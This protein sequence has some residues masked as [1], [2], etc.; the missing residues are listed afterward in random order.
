MLEKGMELTP[1]KVSDKIQSVNPKKITSIES[2]SSSAP[3]SGSTPKSSV[4]GN[5]IKMSQGALDSAVSKAQLEPDRITAQSKAQLERAQADYD[6]VKPSIFETIVNL[7]RTVVDYLSG[8]PKYETEE[9]SAARK[10]LEAAKAG[11]YDAKYGN[12]E[13]KNNVLAYLQSKET[14]SD[15]ENA[16]ER[17]LREALYGKASVAE[18]IRNIWNAGSTSFEKNFADT[19]DTIAGFFGINIGWDDKAG[20]KADYWSEKTAKS[21]AALG[22]DSNISGTLGAAAVAAVPDAVAA[23]I[24]ALLTC[25]A[26]APQSAVKI[27]DTS[28]KIIGAIGK[29]ITAAAKNPFYYTSFAREFGSNYKEAKASGVSDTAAAAIATLTS[30]LNAF[31]EVGGGTGAAGI[32]SLPDRIKD[33]KNPASAV[34]EWV[35]S[36]LDEGKEEAVQRAIS[37]VIAKLTYDS[38]RELN[39]QD[40][41][42]DFASG[43]AVGGLLGGGQLAVSSALNSSAKARLTSVG[44]ML[45]KQGNEAVNDIVKYSLESLN[46][47][48]RAL[49]AASRKNISNENLGRLYANAVN[50]VSAQL[51]SVDSLKQLNTV[52]REI[53]SAGNATVNQIAQAEYIKNLPTVTEKE[54]NSGNEQRLGLVGEA[55]K[56][57]PDGITEIFTEFENDIRNGVVYS[58]DLILQAAKLDA[59]INSGEEISNDE[60]GRFVFDVAL[61]KV[62]S[63]K[64][65]DSKKSAEYNGE[66]GGDL[67]NDNVDTGRVRESFSKSAANNSGGTGEVRQIR[68]EDV[69]TFTRRHSENEGTG[70]GLIKLKAMAVA[71][72]EGIDDN[73]AGYRASQLLSDLGVNAVYCDGNIEINKNGVTQIIG[74]A[75]TLQNGQVLVSGNTTLTAAEIAAHEIV[76]VKQKQ[77]SEEYNAFESCVAENILWNTEN[78]RN[79]A[80]VINASHFNGKMDVESV[81]FADDFLIEVTAYINELV[82]TDINRAERNFAAMCADWQAVVNASRQFNKDI[83]ADFTESAFINGTKTETDDGRSTLFTEA[84]TK[85]IARPLTTEDHIAAMSGRQNSARIRQLNAVAK[86]LGVTLRWNGNISRGRYNP[87]AR[88]VTLNPETTL[89]DAYLFLFKHELTHDLENRKKY[90]LFSEYLYNDSVAFGEYC[91]QK[92]FDYYKEEYAGTREDAINEWT[93]IIYDNY[94][95]SSEIGKPIR[96]KF[97]FTDAKRE[98]IAD[99]VGECLLNGSEATTIK[100]LTEIAA[101]KPTVFQRIRDWVQEEISKLKG[102]KY[103]RTLVEDL[104]YLNKRLARVYNSAIKVDNNRAQDV[105]YSL[106]NKQFPPYSKSQ[107]D[108]NEWATRWALSEN[109]EVGDQKLAS[110]N[111]GW[112]LIEKFDDIE[113]GYQIVE[114]ITKRMYSELKEEIADVRDFEESS[115]AT[116]VNREGSRFRRNNGSSRSNGTFN[117]LSNEYTGKDTEILPLDGGKLG[118]DKVGKNIS[119]FSGKGAERNSAREGN[120]SAEGVT[121]A[122]LNESAFSLPAPVKGEYNSEQYAR[123]LLG[124]SASESQVEG[125]SENLLEIKEKLTAGDYY[126]AVQKAGKVAL[127]VWEVAEEY[128]DVPSLTNQILRDI[129][130]NHTVR[131]E[132]DSTTEKMREAF[133]AEVTRLNKRISKLEASNARKTEQLARRRSEVQRE[134][135]AR[136]DE[137]NNR[138]K[139]IE[140]I[141]REVGNI[142]KKLR[143]NNEKNPVPQELQETVKAFCNVFLRNDQT[144]FKKKDL[145]LVYLAYS[146]MAGEYQSGGESL[147]GTYDFDIDQELKDLISMLDGKTLRQLSL[148]ELQYIRDI[149]DNLR[150]M[151]VNENKL[152]V[153]GRTADIAEIGESALIEMRSRPVKKV[154]ALGKKGA[155]TIFEGNTTPIYFFKKLG[156]T[157]KILFDD[158]RDGQDKWYVNMENAKT[159]ISAT[160]KK[161][162]YSDWNDDTFKFTTV[163]GD[164]IELTREQAMLLYATAKRE[165]NNTAQ[166]AEHLFRGGIVLDFKDDIKTVVRDFKKALKSDA[167]EAESGGDSQKQTRAKEIASAFIKEVNSRAHQITPVDVG[168]VNEWLTDEQ[169]AYADEMVEYLSTDMAALGNETSMQL[170]GIRKYNEKYYIPYN[171]ARNFLYSQ[172]GI[173]G[174]E[175][176]LKHQSFTKQTQRKANNPLLL[177]DFSEVCADHINRMCMYNALTVPLENLNR[178]FNYSNSSDV[179]VSAKDMKAEIERAYGEGAVKYIKKFLEDMNG[180]VRT[181]SIDDVMSRYISLFKKGAVF[182]S[183]SVVVQQPSAIAR[184]FAIVD[185]KYFVATTLKVSERNYE[186]CIKYAP[187]AGIKSMGRF[188]TG[189]GVE[190]VNW[191]LQEEPKGVK[192]KVKALASI[193]DSSYRDDKLSYFAAKADEITWGHIWA[194]IKAE[195]KAETDLTPGTEE[196]FEYAG[197]R[198]RNVIDYTQVYD[199]TLSRSQNM[200]DKSAASKMITAFMAEPTV[201]LNLIMDGVLR[202]KSGDKKAFGRAVAAWVS[203]VLLNSFLKSFVT[204]ARDDNEKKSYLEKYLGN[205]VGNAASDLFIPNMIPIVK[206]VVSIFEGWEVER[207]D[208]SLFSDLA[209]SVEAVWN[210]NKTV[211][212]KIKSIAGSL[213]AFAGLPVKNVIRDIEAVLNVYNDIF[214]GSNETTGAGIGYSILEDLPGGYDGGVTELYKALS[215]AAESGNDKRYQRIYDYLI[216]QGKSD[217]DI[218]SG[219]KSAYKKD[220]ETESAVQKYY[221]KLDGNETFEMLTAEDREKVEKEI[222]NFIAADKY[223]KNTD[224]NYDEYDELYEAYRTDKSKYNRLKKKLLENGATES[225]ISDGFEIARIAYLKKVG[226]DLHEYILAK[227]AMKK[228]YADS[229]DSGGVSK[230]EKRAAVKDMDFD[231]RTKNAILKNL[232]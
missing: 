106:I 35:L 188:D 92:L 172:P 208:M 114:R 128:P 213:A 31:V 162:H 161:Y 199:S 38:D 132:Y 204:A 62:A 95:T 20:Q 56:T 183:A 121:E 112:Y 225:Q 40:L 153:Q 66:N 5:N 72:V 85:E 18:H 30:S 156:D 52:A 139:N 65:V 232:I 13:Q 47:E 226:I 189:V 138:Q 111:G 71:Y 159:F 19:A 101:N 167:K 74:Q 34:K 229:D 187:V 76:H 209:A 93:E 144:V 197:K 179:G 102:E 195:T 151:V 53:V 210:D 77:N 83:G 4:A 23:I 49:A 175:Q 36:S 223:A 165:K 218:R 145:A 70:R 136:R 146:N 196:F 182:S 15:A 164:D 206:D 57:A 6:A 207:A 158:I 11:Y 137:R 125:L 75:V 205:F 212:E 10:N 80:N 7:P 117:N 96:D 91:R 116:T 108:A 134:E 190:N 55:I 24:S 44:K 202:A 191:L 115:S 170:F 37:D 194:A 16:E 48:I 81:D 88:T 63:T 216:E 214:K 8:I 58:K 124:D 127:D 33:V 87:G 178:V 143:A 221:K 166:M 2:L 160:K 17:E 211:G 171:S 41:A 186:Q 90:G 1:I 99:F 181:S 97:S 68:R 163:Y 133:D 230:A 174:S 135:T 103:N 154:L 12:A 203:S 3:Y 105:K 82:S 227:T 192:E 84:D 104:E 148:I 180:A 200:R 27:A 69:E 100:A 89:T 14:K 126:G 50:E 9:Q 73:S 42:V 198:F 118:V 152:F 46:P 43:V 168:I 39:P 231:T 150:H 110:Y 32:Q 122:G 220:T 98:V 61:Q 94:K 79:V 140:Y 173:T 131:T 130:Q 26:T 201:S 222:S 25:G 21:A 54:I 64:A 22:D 59:M 147:L 120:S 224:E 78:Y 217:S 129:E 107:S 86:K 119:R 142:D 184:A 67:N 155:Q 149:V 28:T 45:K 29:A 185:P 193:S 51:T 169:K 141:R 176:R 113:F 177:S 60:L 219:I 215:A 123:T 157:F 109:V 228:A